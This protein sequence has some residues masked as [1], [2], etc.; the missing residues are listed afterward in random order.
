MQDKL[1]IEDGITNDKIEF[2][3]A[4]D[5]GDILRLLRLNQ[6]YSIP[7]MSKKLGMSVNRISKIERSLSQL[8]NEATLRT[9]LDKLGCKKNTNKIL[10]LA[11]S[12]KVS[13]NVR[14][15]SKDTS[16]ADLVRIIE[17]YKDKQLT[18]TD[19]ALLSV[20]ARN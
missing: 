18:E 3:E 13:H 20:I 19:R 2:N 4:D 17:A 16:N 7:H 10:K 14:L 9:W 1:P 15:H 5:I 6:G 11:R 12:H 8:P